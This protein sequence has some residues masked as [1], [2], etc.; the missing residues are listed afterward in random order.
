MFL[1]GFLLVLARRSKSFAAFRVV[2]QVLSSSWWSYMVLDG[3]C[4]FQT[5]VVGFGL[6]Y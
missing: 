3:S 5:V 4:L 1:V 6:T 2:W